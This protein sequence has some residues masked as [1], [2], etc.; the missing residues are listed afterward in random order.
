DQPDHDVAPWLYVPPYP[1][2]SVEH[3]CIVKNIDNGIKSLGGGAVLDK[4]LL[5]ENQNKTIGLS[6]RPEDR[7]AKPIMSR[8]VQQD[9]LVLKVTVPKRT[10]RRRRKGTDGP[11]EDA[12][13]SQDAHHTDPKIM[14]R[15]LRD[16]PHVYSIQPIGHAGEYHR[17]RTLPDFQYAAS[18]SEFARKIRDNIM[19][20]QLSKLKELKLSDTK[21]HEPGQ[22]YCPPPSYTN[23]NVPL[24]YSYRQN[25]AVKIT[26]DDS[27]KNVL[28]NVKAIRG[29]VVHTIDAHAPDVHHA[30]P[31]LPKPEH[32]LDSIT[33][34]VVQKIRAML[35][36]RPV[37]TRRYIKN[38]L[39]PRVFDAQ[40]TAYPYVGYSFR[41]GPWRDTLVKYGVDP[42][43]DPKYRIYQTVMFK[44]N[45]TGERQNKET[46]EHVSWLD[47]NRKWRQKAKAINDSQ[48]K[49]THVFDGKNFFPDGKVWQICDITDPTLKEILSTDNIR[50]DC[51]IDY[52]GWFHNGT[53][54]K[55]KIIMRTKLSGLKNGTNTDVALDAA[56]YAACSEIPDILTKE[57]VARTYL[58]ARDKVPQKLFKMMEEIR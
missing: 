30:P 19:P 25:P 58:K 45:V 35:E 27:G 7:M 16:N 5:S 54:A 18:A 38:H 44:M 57:N 20:F 15:S 1:V 51:D 23:M 47:M 6:L 26:Q 40:R 42:R 52:S 4:F 3:P 22:D 46:G 55:T 33:Q 32:E 9:N 53:W 43:K 31:F 13:V 14:L 10:G 34:E 29:F 21:V 39:P 41:S 48:N 49:E 28:T 24:I 56:A 37:M 36:E 50:S 8:F 2:V 17:F 11:W 12:P